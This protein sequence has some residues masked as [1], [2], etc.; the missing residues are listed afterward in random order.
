M[1]RIALLFIPMIALLSCGTGTPDSIEVGYKL[2]NGKVIMMPAAQYD[3]ITRMDS[4]RK[5]M[6][7]VHKKTFTVGEETYAIE[8]GSD[9]CEYY[10]MVILEHQYSS[11]RRYFHYP[12]C[13]Y[14]KNHK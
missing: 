1:K 8:T 3:Y 10:S 14:C 13:S 11:E 5:S 9:S 4:I 6:P 2:T 12:Q 7:P